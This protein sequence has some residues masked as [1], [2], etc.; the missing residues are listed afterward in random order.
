MGYSCD[1]AFYDIFVVSIVLE[2]FIPRD[3]EHFFNWMVS[4][5]GT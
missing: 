3:L 1:T 4:F 5:K 2:D